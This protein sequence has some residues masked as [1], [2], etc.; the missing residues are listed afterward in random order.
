MIAHHQLPDLPKS[1]D[2]ARKRRKL[3]IGDASD[4]RLI[5][6]KQAFRSSCFM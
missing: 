2:A 3:G 4:R 1:G 5:S 6:A